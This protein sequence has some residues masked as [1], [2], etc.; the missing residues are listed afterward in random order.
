MASISQLRQQLRS[1][2]AE[3]DRNQNGVL[4]HQEIAHSALPTEAKKVLAQ[5][6]SRGANSTG[7]QSVENVRR[8]VETFA[9]DFEKF[10][11]DRSGT[12]S[13][14]EISAANAF[15]QQAQLR[16]MQKLVETDWGTSAP[17]PGYV[18]AGMSFYELRQGVAITSEQ[19][20]TSAE[21]VDETLARQFIAACHQSTYT[22]V[23]TLEDAF[24]AVD[25]GEFVVRTF[26]DPVDGKQYVAIDYGAGDSTYGA[27][28]EAG[29]SAPAFGIQDGELTVP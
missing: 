23:A 7:G 8:W 14:E 21:G 19:R 11:A 27:I 9:D 6:T 5:A 17:V 25:G 10:D 28:F 2:A 13:R 12:L 16:A 15:G 24:A 20:F 18:Q 4:A 26:A 1:A 22:D 3:V 29:N